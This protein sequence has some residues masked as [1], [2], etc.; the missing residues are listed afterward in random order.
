MVF[1]SAEMLTGI[2]GRGAG[3]PSLNRAPLRCRAWTSCTQVL[4]I[5]SKEPEFWSPFNMAWLHDLRCCRDQTHV[6][7]LISSVSLAAGPA[8]AWCYLMKLHNY[9]LPSMKMLNKI[10][11]F[12]H[13]LL[14]A[15][16]QTPQDF[17]FT[18]S[19]ITCFTIMWVCV[20]QFFSRAVSDFL[21]SSIWTI[22]H[23]ILKYF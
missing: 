19:H 3:G 8:A 2:W 1:T 14:K 11:S 4:L 21:S 23:G 7:G 12:I 15:T 10:I 13:H 6:L 17:S 5:H 22:C 18:V 9:P 16:G 20:F